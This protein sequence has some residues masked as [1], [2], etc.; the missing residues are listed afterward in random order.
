MSLNRYGLK[1]HPFKELYG[2]A[3]EC[4]VQERL[5]AD[6]DGYAEY[7]QEIKDWFTQYCTSDRTKFF[8]LEGLRGSGCTSLANYVVHCYATCLANTNEEHNKQWHVLKVP[9]QVE[10]ERNAEVLQGWMDKLDRAII[11]EKIPLD[12]AI[13]EA[14]HKVTYAKRQDL[15]DTP[16]MYRDTFNFVAESLHNQDWCIAGIFDKVKSRDLYAFCRDVFDLWTPLV[17]FVEG[18]QVDTAGDRLT[19]SGGTP[20]SNTE[21]LT[22]EDGKRILLDPLDGNQVIVFLDHCWKMAEGQSPPPFDKEAVKSLFDA[23]P[24]AAKAVIRT[25][26]TFF[27]YKIEQLEPNGDW[28]DNQNLKVGSNDIISCIGKSHRLLSG[29]WE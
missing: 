12:K 20:T 6:I 3:L 15:P 25:L 22:D 5:F 16:G 8:V 4:P 19:P 27:D 14:I 28:P 7:Q 23:S 24:K 17:I 29:G 2:N 13:K 10:S 26:G 9:V 21:W 18:W 1:K 11:R